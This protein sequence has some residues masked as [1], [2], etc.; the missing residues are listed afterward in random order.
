MPDTPLHTD[1]PNSQLSVEHSDDL[2]DM[3][4]II[5]FLDLTLC[6]GEGQVNLDE[7]SQN[8]LKCLLGQMADTIS[9]V[10]SN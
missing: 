6:H 2:M 8:G 10:I 1:T 4:G 9:A 3:L 5:G 7:C